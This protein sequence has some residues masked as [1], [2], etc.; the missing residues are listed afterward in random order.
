MST[1]EKMELDVEQLDKATAET[2][3]ERC[4]FGDEE[5]DHGNADEILCTLLSALGFNKTVEAFRKVEK[6]YA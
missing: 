1:A 6:W 2:I 4:M 5:A 3:A